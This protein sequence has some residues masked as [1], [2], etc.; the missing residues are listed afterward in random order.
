VENA[1]CKAKRTKA[2]PP[3]R[4]AHPTIAFDVLCTL[5]SDS[6]GS[7]HEVDSLSLELILYI[8]WTIE[9]AALVPVFIEP[10]VLSK[11]S[12]FIPLGVE[13]VNFELPI[14][15]AIESAMPSLS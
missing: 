15:P 9:R 1:A 6:S 13:D 8:L 7:A 2:A 11:H 14:A 12:N 3:A 5:G 4:T 10:S